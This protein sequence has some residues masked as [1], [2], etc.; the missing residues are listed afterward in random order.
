MFLHLSIIRRSQR[1]TYSRAFGHFEQIVIKE[2]GQLATENSRGP[3]MPT[4]ANGARRCGRAPFPCSRPSFEHQVERCFGCPP[5]S[6]EPASAHHVSQACL[7]RLGAE[8]GTNFL[9][10]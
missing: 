8:G 2:S 10:Q 5:E 6:R 9:R 3:E 4:R 1:V 7:S